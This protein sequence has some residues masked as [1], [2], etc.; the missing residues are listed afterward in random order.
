MGGRLSGTST[1][2]MPRSISGEAGRA[3]EIWCP[4]NSPLVPL[5]QPIEAVSRRISAPLS[6]SDRSFSRVNE[7]T[8]NSIATITRV[9]AITDSPR[10]RTVSRGSFLPRAT[11]L[12]RGN[13]GRIATS[14]MKRH[15]RLRRQSREE[16]EDPYLQMWRSLTPRERLRRAW[17]LRKRLKNLQAVHDAKSLP[18]L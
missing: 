2:L 3:K 16:L 14:A 5:T 9:T 8:R 10:F 12:P 15:P 18:K 4:Q 7:G 13:R 11:R 6:A 17:R 1:A